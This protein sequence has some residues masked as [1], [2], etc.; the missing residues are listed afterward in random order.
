MSKNPVISVLFTFQK[1]RVKYLLM[2]G[3]ACILYGAAE[4]TRDTDFCVLCDEK[5]LGRITAA[6]SELKAVRV[7]YPPC[8]IAYLQ[9]GHA[10]HFECGT[11]DTKGFRIDIM[12]KLRGCPDFQ[13]LWAKRNSIRIDDMSVP[14]MG[15]RHLVSA[16]KTQRDK[17]WPMIRRLIENDYSSK[18]T[19]R[20]SDLLW[21]FS[22]CRTPGLLIN[23]GEKHASLCRKMALKRPLLRFALT[24]NSDAL[25][26]SLMEEELKER[27]TDREYWAP[28]KMEIERMRHGR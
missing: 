2:G 15:L 23:L 25:E 8:E 3:Q 27:R 19:P 10:C 14:V 28:L 26:K 21:W 24:K 13:E 17:D 9:K 7:F 20:T 22:D 5:N 16:K 1:H 12:A 6:L 11:R 4:F 18:K